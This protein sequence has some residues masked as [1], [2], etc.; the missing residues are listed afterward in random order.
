MVRTLARFGITPVSAL[1]CRDLDPS[2][3]IA[4]RPLPSADDP[5]HPGLPAARPALLEPADLTEPEDECALAIHE[6]RWR[7]VN[8]DAL[9]DRERALIDRPVSACGTGPLRTEIWPLGAALSEESP[10]EGADG[11]GKPPDSR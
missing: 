3:S 9:T 2:F 5:P 1:E 10:G 7:H 8:E 11:R 4:S 6:D